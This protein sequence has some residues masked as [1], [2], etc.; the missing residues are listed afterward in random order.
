MYT[1]WFNASMLA[2][3]SGSV[4]YRRLL[5][6]SAGECDFQSETQLMVSEKIAASMEAAFTLMTGGSVDTVIQR[7]RE[8]VAANA[9][10]LLPSG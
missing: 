5:K 3:E 1:S 9:D 4:A 2:V 8:H 6:V 10:R 7:Y